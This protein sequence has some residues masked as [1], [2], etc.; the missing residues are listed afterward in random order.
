MKM[1]RLQPPV[2]HTHPD[3]STVRD[4]IFAPVWAVVKLQ[5]WWPTMVAA[6][7]PDD[8]LQVLLGSGGLQGG[9]WP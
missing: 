5:V 2:S 8:A 6:T 4:N 3:G 1:V 9:P 7:N